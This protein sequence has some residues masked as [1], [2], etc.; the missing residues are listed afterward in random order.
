MTVTDK[1][2][3]SCVFHSCT[4]SVLRDLWLKG[5]A[6]L[7]E[8]LKYQIGVSMWGSMLMSI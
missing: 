6:L 7:L 3:S 8:D 5:R 2:E 4:V 1:R